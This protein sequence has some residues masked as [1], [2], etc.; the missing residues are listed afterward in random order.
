MNE[1]RGIASVT[2]FVF[3]KILLIS[4]LFTKT[5]SHTFESIHCMSK[6]FDFSLLY[7]IDSCLIFLAVMVFIGS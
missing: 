5:F 4:K 1:R 3:I 7:F 6:L 2:E